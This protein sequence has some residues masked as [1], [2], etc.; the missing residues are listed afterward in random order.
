M[1]SEK[2]SN[3]ISRGIEYIKSPLTQ[4]ARVGLASAVALTGVVGAITAGEEYLRNRD[5]N[6]SDKKPTDKDRYQTILKLRDFLKN[7]IEKQGK[8][9]NEIEKLAQDLE[10]ACKASNE[11]RAALD[12][13][14]HDFGI[15]VDN[16]EQLEAKA[17]D[18]MRI[19]YEKYL[20]YTEKLEASNVNKNMTSQIKSLIREIKNPGI[21]K[22]LS[23][24]VGLSAKMYGVKRSMRKVPMYI[25]DSTTGMWQKITNYMPTM[26]QNIVNTYHT[27]VDPVTGVVY[28]GYKGISNLASQA[29]NGMYNLGSNAYNNL[30]KGLNY[31]T[32]QM[33]KREEAIDLGRVQEEARKMKMH[34]EMVRGKQEEMNK[35]I[36]NMT[37]A[38][39]YALDKQ[40]AELER[41][42]KE[43]KQKAKAGK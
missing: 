35:M 15:D 17:E 8:I 32:P 31:I 18:A 14:E 6:E 13:A 1:N 34:Q 7:T 2:F 25:V 10:A 16:Y 21:T 27:L 43:K 22:R 40:I 19:A 36:A 11:A 9:D 20:N 24:K 5:N 29:G 41:R 23:K 4:E 33:L 12:Q 42:E 26:P 28:S 30:A 39:R 37:P 38:E 3:N